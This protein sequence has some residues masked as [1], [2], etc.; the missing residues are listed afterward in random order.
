MQI[1]RQRK[2]GK[3]RMDGKSGLKKMGARG[4]GIRWMVRRI[5]ISIKLKLLNNRGTGSGNLG[6]G[7]YYDEH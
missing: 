3:N 5:L 4:G 7:I 1:R 6:I 2:R